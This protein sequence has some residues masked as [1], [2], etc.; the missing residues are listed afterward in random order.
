MLRDSPTDRRV[1]SLLAT[2]LVLMPTN[3]DSRTAKEP[4][5]K[6]FSLGLRFSAETGRRVEQPKLASHVPLP[7][8]LLPKKLLRRFATRQCRTSNKSTTNMRRPA[9]QSRPPHP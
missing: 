8:K 6:F 7:D 1:A 9:L 5:T 2:K 4:C 3:S